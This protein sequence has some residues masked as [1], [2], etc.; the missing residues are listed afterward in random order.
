MA[1]RPHC[2][3][4]PKKNLSIR[5]HGLTC[6]I[7]THH[8]KRLDRLCLESRAYKPLERIT[9][10]DPLRYS[11][12]SDTDDEVAGT[13]LALAQ[14]SKYFVHHTTNPRHF[15]LNMRGFPHHTQGHSCSRCN[16]TTELLMNIAC[17]CTT[18]CGQHS[19]QKYIPL[20]LMTRKVT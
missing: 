20:E 14:S 4:A 13:G 15:R 5:V 6:R 18:T 3:G 9:A 12:G 10:P 17:R 16:D 2:K 7:I 8:N 1:L 11:L 19:G